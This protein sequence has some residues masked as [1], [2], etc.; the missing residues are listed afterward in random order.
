MSWTPAPGM[1]VVC[2]DAADTN[3][4]GIPE[5]VE[6]A[7]YSIRAIVD[8]DELANMLFGRPL[9]EAGLLLVEVHRVPLPELGE[10]PFA[11]SR[12]RPI[13]DMVAQITRNVAVPA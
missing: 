1:K 7:V 10:V 12:F 3:E 8:P 5:I 11:V 4:Q 2:I 6:G 13:D 9:D